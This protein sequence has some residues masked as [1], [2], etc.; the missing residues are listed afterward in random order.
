MKSRIIFSHE[1]AEQ[2]SWPVCASVAWWCTLTPDQTPHHVSSSSVSSHRG[3]EMPHHYILFCSFI[4]QWMDFSTAACSFLI[5]NVFD[6]RYIRHSSPS[7]KLWSYFCK[8]H[9]IRRIPFPQSKESLYLRVKNLGLKFMTIK[10]LWSFFCDI[11]KL[12]YMSYWF[13]E[14]G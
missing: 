14:S 13:L 4:A 2:G 12:K 5:E 8:E 3:Q 1:R 10:R 9:L 7:C 11:L 6:I